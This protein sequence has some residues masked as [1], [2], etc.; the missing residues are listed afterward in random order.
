M[1]FDASNAWWAARPP[2]LARQ[3][4]EAVAELL[5]LVLETPF[6]TAGSEAARAVPRAF[7]RQRAKY[8]SFSPGRISG[9]VGIGSR[10]IDE[11]SSESVSSGRATRSS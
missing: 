8:A 4:H 2:S 3:V 7:F 5:D 9:R 1:A 10:P 11:H 6:E